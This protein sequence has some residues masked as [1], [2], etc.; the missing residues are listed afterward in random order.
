MSDT[1]AILAL[2]NNYNPK[3]TATVNGKKVEILRMNHAFKS[4]MFKKAGEYSVVF[5]YKDP[6]LWKMHLFIFLGILLIFVPLILFGNKGEENI[7]K[8]S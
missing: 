5:E 7:T 6:L 4:I 1:P 2:T 8:K 3:W